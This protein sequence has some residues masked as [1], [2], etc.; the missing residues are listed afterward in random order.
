MGY[1][2]TL[3]PISKEEINYFVIEP[4]ADRSLI[5]KRI[6]ELSKDDDHINFLKET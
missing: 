5:D 6:G 2:I 4:F 1:D 3:H